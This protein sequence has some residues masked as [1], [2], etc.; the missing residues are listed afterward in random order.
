M[1]HINLLLAQRL[2][3]GK[4]EL[5][6]L[7]REFGGVNIALSVIVHRINHLFRCQGAKSTMCK[8]A[9]ITFAAMICPYC[10]KAY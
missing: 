8:I 10:V 3:K 4:A 6:E 9:H 5:V 2:L 7:V 1:E